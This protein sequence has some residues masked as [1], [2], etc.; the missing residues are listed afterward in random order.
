[1]IYPKNGYSLGFTLRGADKQA[2]SDVTFFQ[3][4][5]HAKYIH[6]LTDNSRLIFSG[7]LGYTAIDDINQLHPALQ[8][9]AGGAQSLRGYQYRSLGP[10]R[11]LVVGSSAIEQRIYQQWFVSGFYDI[12][13][14]FD[15][16]PIRMLHDIGV[17]IV[18]VTA[19]GPIRIGIAL[20]LTGESKKPRF[21]FSMGPD[22]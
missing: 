3:A 13:N 6:S 18:R 8:Y 15:Q 17:G 20:P 14:V 4:H 2:F 19:L 1:M 7:T 12:G 16:R 11:Y 5:A 10:G 9:F 22:L 21:V